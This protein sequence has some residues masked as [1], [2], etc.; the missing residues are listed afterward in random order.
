MEDRA[1]PEQRNA[2]F[3]QGSVTCESELLLI[4]VDLL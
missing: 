4:T 3:K 1:L 2:E